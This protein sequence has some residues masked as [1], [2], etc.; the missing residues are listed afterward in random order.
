MSPAND[1]KDRIVRTPTTQPVLN[2]VL[3][4]RIRQDDKWGEQNWPSFPE[5]AA[6][7]VHRAQHYGVP[8]EAL[9]KHRSALPQ[10]CWHLR[11]YLCRGS[12]R[13][14]RRTGRRPSARG[15][16]AGCRRRGGVDRSHRPPQGEG[17]CSV[18]EP[19][20]TYYVRYIEMDGSWSPWQQTTY[21]RWVEAQD[22][23][24]AE[25][26]RIRHEE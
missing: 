10:S 18:S 26:M 5:W 1:N 24:D 8:T 17:A 14:H 22:D 6:N 15:A 19:T 20:Y 21:R 7:A 12:G 11:R 3:A 16:G 9:A 2:E 13:S 4:E 23:D 25:T